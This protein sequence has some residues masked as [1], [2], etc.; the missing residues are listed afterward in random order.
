MLLEAPFPPPTARRTPQCV[1]RSDQIEGTEA[2]CDPRRAK[3][4]VTVTQG[5]GEH[6]AIASLRRT[7]GEKYRTTKQKK[8]GTNKHGVWRL[9]LPSLL[10]QQPA[11]Q[12][13]VINGGTT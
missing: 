11:L 1:E 9:P 12:P 13:W 2:T 4:L 5:R 6:P 3:G 10:S 7:L 8:T